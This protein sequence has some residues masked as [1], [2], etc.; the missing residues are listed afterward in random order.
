MVM[1]AAAVVMLVFFRRKGWIGGG[2]PTAST[3]EQGESPP[4]EQ[5]P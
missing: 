5:T 3:G 4:R 2:R 1:A